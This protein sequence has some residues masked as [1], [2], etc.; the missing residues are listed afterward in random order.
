MLNF[1]KVKALI[2]LQI[3]GFVIPNE[4]FQNSLIR[5]IIIT[6]ALLLR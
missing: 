1:L 5:I 6:N 4:V 2:L 3:R